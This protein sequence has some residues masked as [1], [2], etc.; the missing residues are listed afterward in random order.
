MLLAMTGKGDEAK[1]F[2]YRV[3]EEVA[4]QIY[5]KIESYCRLM[6]DMFNLVKKGFEGK[7]RRS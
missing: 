1:I 6:E 7:K 4:E 5:K 2:S 3:G